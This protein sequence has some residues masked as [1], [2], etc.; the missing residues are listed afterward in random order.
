MHEIG[1]DIGSVQRTW[2]TGRPLVGHF[3]AGLYEVVTA[4]GKD[5]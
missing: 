5:E 2:P 4:Y 1:T 3:G